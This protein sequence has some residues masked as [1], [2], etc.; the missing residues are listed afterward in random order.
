MQ[1]ASLASLQAL[2]SP[3]EAVEEEEAEEEPSCRFMAHPLLFHD[4]RI[5]SNQL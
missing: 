2:P 5:V 3:T 4:L 1:L